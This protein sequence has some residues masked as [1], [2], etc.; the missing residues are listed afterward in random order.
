MTHDCCNM[1]DHQNTVATIIPHGGSVGTTTSSPTKVPSLLQPPPRSSYP[2]TTMSSTNTVAEFMHAVGPGRS[3]EQVKFYIEQQ[4]ESVNVDE[5]SLSSG[6]R[7]IHLAAYYGNLE[8][9]RYLV[10]VAHVNV[11]AVSDDGWTPLH[12]ASQRGN[13][14]MVQYLVEKC[15]VNV[16][17]KD[18]DGFIALHLASGKGHLE[19][20]QY[21]VQTCPDDIVTTK[22]TTGFTAFH[23]ACQSGHLHVVRYLVQDCHVDVTAKTNDGS[24]ALHLASFKGHLNIIRYIMEDFQLDVH[25]KK[26]EPS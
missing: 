14:P 13:L 12:L 11:N 5:A 26:E 16:M 6:F 25:G 19:V 23:L 8:I 3:L 2:H 18:I 10:D 24:T 17:I 1:N 9:L 7:A 20:V 15:H 4:Q 22:S 21:F